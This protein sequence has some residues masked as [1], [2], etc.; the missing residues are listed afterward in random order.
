M[1]FLIDAQLP[2]AVCVWI[3]AQGHEA[4]HVASVL[5]G[6]S[7]D[8]DIVA[9][10]VA[11]GTIIMSKDE[12]FAIRFAGAGHRLVWLR[13]GNMRTPDLLAWLGAR[14]QLTERLLGSGEMLVELR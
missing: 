5:A 8:R 10:A 2:P 11:H 6:D 3:A 7:A 12:D 4:Q 1:K 9:Y 13:C 14:W